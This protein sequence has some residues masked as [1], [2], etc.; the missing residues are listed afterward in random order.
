[1]S[2]SLR[3]RP[4][5]VRI[6]ICPAYGARGDATMGVIAFC[7]SQSLSLPAV[8]RPVSVLHC[9]VLEEVLSLR[10]GLPHAGLARQQRG[11]L[12]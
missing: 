1:M 5:N 3:A 12:S 9:R 4:E 11:C 2:A 7:L 8:C 10:D 6:G